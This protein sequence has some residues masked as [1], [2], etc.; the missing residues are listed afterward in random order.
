MPVK[1]PQIVLQELQATVKV[2]VTPKG[3][4]DKYAQETSLENMFTNGMFSVE[5]LPELKIYVKLL[6]DDSVM[7]KQKLE[8][9]IEY[10]EAEQKKIAMINAEAQMMQQ[11]ANQFLNADPEA[12]ASQVGE[13]EQTIA[14]ANAETNAEREGM[15]D[16]REATAE[17]RKQITQE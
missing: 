6:D 14:Q 15:A 10:I 5:K 12:Q 17:E 13:A 9:A 7:P 8:D 1:I 2:D 4:Y 3:A 16:E 11:R